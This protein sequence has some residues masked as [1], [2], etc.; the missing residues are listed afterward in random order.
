[1]YTSERPTVKYLI[2]RKLECAKEGGFQWGNE[3]LWKSLAH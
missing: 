1:M 2:G 3:D